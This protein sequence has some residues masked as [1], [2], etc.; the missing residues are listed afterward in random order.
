M[1]VEKPMTK[2][3][4]REATTKRLLEVARVHFA[5]HGYAQTAKKLLKKQA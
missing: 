1:A 2:A 4:Q 3:A 5:K